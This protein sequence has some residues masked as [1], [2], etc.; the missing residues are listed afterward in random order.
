MKQICTMFFVSCLCL[1]LSPVSRV[2]AQTTSVEV[3]AK[4]SLQLG[5]AASVTAAF[6]QKAQ[7]VAGRPSTLRQ[8]VPGGSALALNLKSSKQEGAAELFFGDVAGA[9]HSSF[10]VKVVGA[11]VTGE[12]VMRDQ[13]KYYSFT[14]RPDG[15]VY[16][17]EKDIDKILCVTYDQAQ[18]EQPVSDP[19]AASRAAAIPV[20]ES[21]PG[22]GAVVYLDLDGQTV[23]GTLWNTNF[24]GGAP[25]VAAP[26]SLT[27]AQIL[28]VW[29][30]MAEDFRPFALNVTTNEAVFN[31]APINRRMRVIFT[32][33]NYF[34]PG[35]GGVAYLNSFIWGG[36]SRGETPCW[37]WNSGIIG[38][39]EAGSHEVGHTLSLSHDGRTTPSEAYFQGQ[40]SWAPIM[41]VGYYRPVVQWSKGEYPNA[42]NTEDDLL[43][44]T[45]LNGFTYRGDD[46]G[47]TS[48]GA[49]A[50]S[51]SGAGVI[52]ASNQGVITTRTDVDVFSFTTSGGTV[53]LNVNP[54]PDYPNLDIALVLRN[55]ANAVVAS[56]DPA[57]LNASIS[58]ALPAGT[59]YLQIDGVQGALG[60]NS[61]YA[62]LGAY[63]IS[64][65]VP[66]NV[67]PTVSITSPVSGATFIAPAT[68]NI[69]ATATDANGTVAKVEFY[70]GATLLGEDLTAP[71][72]YS[73]T[74]V[75]AGTYTL[76]TKATDNNGAAT[77]SAGVTVTVNEN[78]AP[79]VSITAP[80]SGASYFAPATINIAAT[81]ADVD[82]TVTKVE[83]YSGA[84]K[85]GEDLTAPYTYS[86]VGVPVGSYSL[87]AKATDS[88]DATT[89]SAPVLVSVTVDTNIPP[90]VAI[91]QPRTGASFTA[92]A[93]IKIEAIAFDAD[94]T[95]AKV[96]FYNGATKIGESIVAGPG[97]IYS[98]VWSG[99]GAGSYT[100]TAR[101]IDNNSGSRFSTPVVVTVG[102][103][104]ELIPV[105][106]GVATSDV[107]VYP[108]PASDDQLTI[109][110]QAPA[111]QQLSL[112]LFNATGQR[113]ASTQHSLSLGDNQVRMSI[114][115]LP[116]GLY[117]LVG[118]KGAD[119]F[120]QRILIAH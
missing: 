99:V 86:W 34:Y 6:R 112:A 14:S 88:N 103:G 43:K 120:T 97:S 64:G 115:T 65:T 108:N 48:A 91:A 67:A 96:E 50:L 4:A 21:L 7:A 84:T 83:F 37:V 25:I 17:E 68:I 73:W 46:H 71:Y 58:Q 110:V 80:A 82:G 118:Q 16:L 57:G 81:A 33:T 44:I 32:P 56:A 114:A 60:A 36:T 8:Q 53:T 66:S 105:S 94:G 15:V 35:A 59:Y 18:G 54:N 63:F 117:V 79:T 104:T 116:S 77:T 38:A 26:S 100:L 40:E 93:T 13:K 5:S 52:A 31:S 61:D 78:V 27:E 76:T 11:Q 51:V 106:S 70:N 19:S 47:N 1:W 69:A 39:G 62:S 90:K 95:V 75:A 22:A 12:I 113:V 87:T 85:I 20:L 3:P 10:Y 109:A 101:A 92:P 55:S 42:N 111:E 30:I 102:G 2:L 107:Q 74:G 89:T 45:T 23:S 119:T 49:T 98:F 29:K 28:A 9:A 72:T 41:G 24:N